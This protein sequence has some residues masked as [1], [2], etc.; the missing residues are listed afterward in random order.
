[1]KAAGCT[2]F[3]ALASIF[4]AVVYFLYCLTQID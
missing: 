2:I 3:I 4:A 1:M